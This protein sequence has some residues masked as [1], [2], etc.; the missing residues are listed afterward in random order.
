[1]DLFVVSWT[2][3][4]R[5]ENYYEIF[6][7]IDN[8]KLFV[9]ILKSMQKHETMSGSFRYLGRSIYYDFKETDCEAYMEIKQLAD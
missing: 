5:S 7:D 3:N 2:G 8:A 4:N 9:S 6:K 1:M